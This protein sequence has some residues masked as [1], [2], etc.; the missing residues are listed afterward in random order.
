MKAA[1]KTRRRT[2]NTKKL[3]AGGGRL[4]KIP[5]H[6][7]PLIRLVRCSAPTDNTHAR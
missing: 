5:T 1:G 4:V 3:E 2:V 7:L 6:F